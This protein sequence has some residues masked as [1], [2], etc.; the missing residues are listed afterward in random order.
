M[1]RAKHGFP[2]DLTTE[3]PA[4]HIVNLF[5]HKCPHFICILLNSLLLYSHQGK[6]QNIPLLGL[7]RTCPKLFGNFLWELSK[8][9]EA[10]FI[11]LIVIFSIDTGDQI[12]DINGI[13]ISGSPIEK[14]KE[15]IKESPEYVVC[16][17]KPVTHYSNNDSPTLPSSAYTEID[18][19]YL[20]RVPGDNNSNSSSKKNDSHLNY[21]NIEVH[22]PHQ[23][24][25]AGAHERKAHPDDQANYV[26]I[27]DKGTV[28]NYAELDF[29]RH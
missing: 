23:E 19:E 17:V 25:Q 18:T 11:V 29:S 20:K 10:L 13:R 2:I 1:I 26:N 14:I 4:V 9:C 5:S 15:V 24:E 21:A 12:V 8:A 3:L 22:H 28:Q 7:V 6:G 27:R 16:T